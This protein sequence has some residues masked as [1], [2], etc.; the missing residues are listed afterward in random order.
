MTHEDLFKRGRAS[1]SANMIP[2]KTS[3]PKG[4]ITN[5]FFVC[6]A[7][8]TSSSLLHNHDTEKIVLSLSEM[9]HD[10]IFKRGWASCFSSQQYPPEKRLSTNQ[11]AGAPS[12]RNSDMLAPGAS[13]FEE[14][15]GRE[16][17]LLVPNREEKDD[18]TINNS[19]WWFL[20]N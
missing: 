15:T 18:T 9:T 11:F 14:G 5:Q 17:S 19:I 4:L 8:C 3:P 20:Y 2:N 13:K 7:A 16:K 1:C 10:D 6:P 12:S